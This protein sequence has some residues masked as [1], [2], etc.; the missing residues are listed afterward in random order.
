MMTVW[1]LGYA[2]ANEVA[3]Y[4]SIS[5]VRAH[6]LIAQLVKQG[7]LYRR[8]V[9]GIW[10]YSIDTWWVKDNQDIK[11]ML[12]AVEMAKAEGFDPRQS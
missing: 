9:G 11:A 8:K 12:E 3:D 1:A 5:Q 10:V 7:I 4:M 6:Q 2:T